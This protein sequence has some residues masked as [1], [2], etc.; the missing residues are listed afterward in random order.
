MTTNFQ[1]IIEFHTSFGLPHHDTVSKQNLQNFQIISL[2]IKLIQ[3]EYTELE[4]AKDIIEQLDAIGDLLYVVYGAG[5]SFGFNLDESFGY[6]RDQQLKPLRYA[7]TAR[8]VSNTSNFQKTLH[9]CK[10]L[11][12]LDD[13]TEPKYILNE[14]PLKIR[15]LSHALLMCNTS[16]VHMILID[17]LFDLYKV[18][19]VCHYNLDILFEEIH[20]SNMSKLCNSEQEAID[21]VQW[22]KNNQQD[23][24][25]QPIYEKIGNN[26]WVIFDKSTGKR[27][28][29]IKYSPP[30]I[31]S[32][33]LSL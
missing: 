6:H 7:S 28:K 23:R 18:G 8:N 4:M 20:R 5:S 11:N 33:N 13:N 26:K 24:Y 1:K 29:S 12:I 19:Y 30:F 31:S 14:F 16:S 3:E 21:T 27:L 25:P 9:I 10:L 15:S 17:M 2:R 22:Y 32:L